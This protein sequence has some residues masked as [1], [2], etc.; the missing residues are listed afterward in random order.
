[1][2]E[3][4]ISIGRS[5]KS[6]VNFGKQRKVDFVRLWKIDVNLISAQ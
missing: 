5:A 3:M 6:K 2:F 4:L 1:M